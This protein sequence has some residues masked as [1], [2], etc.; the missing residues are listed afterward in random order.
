MESPI[1]RR[2]LVRGGV[3]LDLYAAAG[4]TPNILGEAIGG[5]GTAL[6]EAYDKAK[7]KSDAINKEEK[8]LLA[9]ITEGTGEETLVDPTNVEYEDPNDTA[10]EDLDNLINDLRKKGYGP[11]AT[12]PTSGDTYTYDMLG[13]DAKA[14][15]LKKNPGQFALAEAHANKTIQEA[16]AY[17]V[18][19]YGT[20]DPTKNVTGVNNIVNVKKTKDG[21]YEAGTAEGKPV[22]ESST[23]FGSQGVI[24]PNLYRLKNS[25]LDRRRINRQL[26]QPRQ[27]SLANVFGGPSQTSYLVGNRS[28]PSDAISRGEAS[29]YTP[30]RTFVEKERRLSA[31]AWMGIGAAAIEGYNMGVEKR[32]YDKQV[33]ADLADY[34]AN[35]FSGLTAER[36]GYDLFDN[37]VKALLFDNKKELAAHLAKREEMFAEGKGPEWSAMLGDLKKPAN[38]VIS[39]VE[40]VKGYMDQFKKDNDDDSIDYSAMPTT[41][42]DEVL[43]YVRGGN[44]GVAN[45]EGMGTALIGE[46]RGKMPY[47]KSLAAI[48]SEGKGPKYV[49]KKNAFD[50]VNTVVDMIRKD[51]DKYSTTFEDS[52][53]IKVKKPM[54]LEQ[55][56]PYLNRMFDAELDSA[57]VTRAYASPNNWD[58]DGLTA[59]QFDLSVKAGKDPK[60]FVK[61]K[62][63]EVAGDL[64]AP[65]FGTT[66]TTTTARATP[67]GGR[68][69]GTS[70]GLTPTQQKEKQRQDSLLAEAARIIGVEGITP[71]VGEVKEPNY[72]LLLGRKGVGRV[73]K[74]GNQLIIYGKRSGSSQMEDELKRIP[75]GDERTAA[76]AVANFLSED[77][78][79]NPRMGETFNA[80]EYIKT[81]NQRGK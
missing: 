80:A 54:T 41:Q 28:V 23:T 15:F 40:G 52:N 38:E 34:Y 53:G 31:P 20:E 25:P 81:F 55:L 32:N 56:A 66:E 39:L 3:D 45:V 26:S 59:E 42:V 19:K 72:N 27:S 44:I 11:N 61:K 73:E 60:D 64:L 57:S 67:G 49:K 78:T 10:D 12:K 76:E 43:S 74:V 4:K 22:V 24:N 68:T 16:K 75:L 17:N 1:K 9:A 69:G 33:Q 35:E 65:Y 71:F 48:I 2:Q 63:M 37:S 21:E 50:Y 46:T 14:E 7:K 5:I 62:F 70:G 79:Y 51:P 47:L 6:G 29:Q 36:T 18:K 8:D 13:E 77:K 58:E 30:G